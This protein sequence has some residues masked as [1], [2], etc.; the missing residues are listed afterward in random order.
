MT[1]PVDAAGRPLPTIKQLSRYYFSQMGLIS[2]RVSVVNAGARS[3]PA[4]MVS[5]HGRQMNEMR[6]GQDVGLPPLAV[7]MPP[8]RVA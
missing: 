5:S 8:K 4:A 3:A 1:E 2:C 6:A 7:R